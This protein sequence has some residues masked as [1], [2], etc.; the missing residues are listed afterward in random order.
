MTT[1]SDASNLKSGDGGQTDVAPQIFTRKATGL[2][3]EVRLAD[4]FAF[5]ASAATPIGLF[6]ALNLFVVFAAFPGANLIL[7]LV[8][9]GVLLPLVWVT[10][11]LMGAALPGVGGDYLYGSRILH[12]IAG[13][14]S[15]LGVYTGAI[16]SVGLSSWAFVQLG[17]A[18]VLTTVGVV[19]D[20]SGWI[21]AGHTVGSRG[22]TFAI[23]AMALLVITA[24]SVSG[25]KKVARTM[26]WAYFIAL[27]S[28]VVSL[29]ILL[30]TSHHHFVATI[31]HLSASYTHESNTYSATIAAGAKNG[32]RYPNHGGYSGASTLG[33]LFPLILGLNSTF[34]GIYLAGEMKGAG[35][36]S[37]QLIAQTGS[38][39]FQLVLTL[40][41]AGIFI[42]AAGYDFVA[43]ASN[44][45]FGVPAS[46]YFT[47]FASAMAGGT[48][49]PLILGCTFLLAVPPVLYANMALC[50][51]VPF[52]LAFDG[53][54]PKRLAKVNA[55]THTPVTAI[56]IT[57]VI[58]LGCLYFAAYTK[59]FITVVTYTG[60]CG[61]ACFVVVG[62]SAAAMKWRRPELYYG[63]SAEWRVAGIDVLPVL[64]AGLAALGLLLY[65]LVFR[66]HATLGIKNLA[67]AIE[68]LVGLGALAV[69]LYL[70]AKAGQRRAGIDIDL[71]YKTIPSD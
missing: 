48:V 20:R 17:L 9:C 57:S 31:N 24:L 55:R 12:P 39:Y 19:T 23:G 47:F 25:T 7:D 54:L 22:W 67:T 14:F 2:V 21:N 62:I 60:L 40:V 66:F 1:A 36:R 38:G 29:V 3:R 64:G 28:T 68:V 70:G 63:S 56:V 16:L 30:L 5:N 44:G 8:I 34:Y 50:Q 6:L 15:N 42:S 43:A 45:G 32:L 49:L 53:L 58:G 59:T 35:K 46:P 4:M 26:A 10:F 27:G 61:F 18:P 69:A 52:A 51:R 65:Y 41:G 11:S 13:L 37:R 71:A 33:A